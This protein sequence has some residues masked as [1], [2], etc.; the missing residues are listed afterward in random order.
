MLTL[1]VGNAA[2]RGAKAHSHSIRGPL[3]RPGEAGVFER[4]QRAGDAELRVTIEPFQAM[5]R[6]EPCGIPVA[7]LAAA[8][9]L[10]LARIEGGDPR[11]P[12]PSGADVLPENFASRA[13]AGDRSNARN[14][15]AAAHTK[16]T[17]I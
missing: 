5:R 2:Q 11:D 13:D 15:D 9:R 1:G 14:D 16:R 8:M 7:N 17:P 12:A 6:E 10:Q 3:A 4:K